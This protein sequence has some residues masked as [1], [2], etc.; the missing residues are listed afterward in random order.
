MPTEGNIGKDRD[1]KK[2]KIWK[3]RATFGKLVPYNPPE[4]K[5][6]Y[7]ECSFFVIGQIACFTGKWKI[8]SKGVVGIP[9]YFKAVFNR[10]MP[11][12]EPFLF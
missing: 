12:R 11:L 8:C 4:K 1:S 3:A 2:G 10:K 9:D 7:Y 6:F 5:T